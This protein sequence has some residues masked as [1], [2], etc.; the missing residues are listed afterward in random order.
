MSVTTLL[1]RDSAKHFS[2]S[3]ESRRHSA[4]FAL[5]FLIAGGRQNAGRPPGLGGQ[6]DEKI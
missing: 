4:I 1:L 6:T 2:K 5:S 3:S